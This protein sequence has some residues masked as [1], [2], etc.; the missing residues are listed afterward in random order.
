MNQ[1]LGTLIDRV[2]WDGGSSLRSGL[3]VGGWPGRIDLADLIREPVRL[4]IEGSSCVSIAPGLRALA[5]LSDPVIDSAAP[6]LLTVSCLAGGEAV[7]RHL[8]VGLIPRHMGSRSLQ[9]LTDEGRAWLM[10]TALSLIDDPA[11][12]RGVCDRLPE[13]MG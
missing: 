4:E 1:T 9:P 6:W 13:R 8:S 7:R 11:V 2:A 3:I 5:E 12:L 10:R